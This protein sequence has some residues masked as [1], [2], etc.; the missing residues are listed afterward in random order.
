VSS[1]R[2]W[3]VSSYKAGGSKCTKIHL[4]EFGVKY[5]DFGATYM[6]FGA[7]Y[8]SFSAIYLIFGAKI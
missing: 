8:L 2:G 1:W 6:S 4:F 3:E 5:V 7:I